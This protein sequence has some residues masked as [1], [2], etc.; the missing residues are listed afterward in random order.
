MAKAPCLVRR[1]LFPSNNYAEKNRGLVVARTSSSVQQT[2]RSRCP[3]Q[4]TGV[5]LALFCGVDW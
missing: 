1:I 2:A 5:S 3:I 4:H